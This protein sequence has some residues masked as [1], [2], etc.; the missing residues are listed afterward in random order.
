MSDGIS[1]A[2]RGVYF[3]KNKEEP[4]DSSIFENKALNE[5]REKIKKERNE[6]I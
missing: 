3:G 6:S 2:W 4:K 1:D 5:I